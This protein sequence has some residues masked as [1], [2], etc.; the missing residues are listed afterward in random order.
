MTVKTKVMHGVNT[1]E[2]KLNLKELDGDTSH[3]TSEVQSLCH[4]EKQSNAPS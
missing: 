4:S 2:K 1:F 3:K